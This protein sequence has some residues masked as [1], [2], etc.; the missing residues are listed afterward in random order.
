MLKRVKNKINHIVDIEKLKKK[1]L[2]VGKDVSIG[3][4]CR[5][6]SSFSFL[7]DIGDRVTLAPNVLV[8]AHDT[9]TKQMT[10]FTK[11]GKVTI[12]SDVY[13][14]PGSILLPGTDIGNNVIVKA[15]TVIEEKI[16][17]NSVVSGNP[18]KIISTYDEYKEKAEK[19]ISKSRPI[20][21]KTA[22]YLKD[23]EKKLIKQRIGDKGS[24]IK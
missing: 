7:I 16:P 6:D 22:H 3:S 2:T 15:G 23:V 14:G 10:G 5:I 19:E 13:I 21:G 17:E 4:G 20:A 24:Y 1:G 18:A 8:F 11:M 12:G 9:S